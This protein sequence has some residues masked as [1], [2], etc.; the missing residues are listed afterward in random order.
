MQPREAPSTCMPARAQVHESDG[1]AVREGS[2]A[3]A[4]PGAKPVQERRERPNACIRLGVDVN[5]DVGPPR[6]DRFEPGNANPATAERG[7]PP[8]I[9]GERLTGIGR[10]HLGD[11]E[12]CD[13]A[14]AIR[15]PV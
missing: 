12:L 3:H 2:N 10:F 5:P 15:D 9:Q 4:L 6:K 7:R 11:A 13:R 14:G 1:A 8:T